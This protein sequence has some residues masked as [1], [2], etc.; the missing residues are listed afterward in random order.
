MGL[1]G[2]CV[3]RFNRTWTSS[4]EMAV[5]LR[6]ELAERMEEHKRWLEELRRSQQAKRERSAAL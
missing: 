2:N 6:E 4:T 5:I 1:S 3:G